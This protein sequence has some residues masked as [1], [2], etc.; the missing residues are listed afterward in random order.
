MYSYRMKEMIIEHGVMGS[1]GTCYTWNRK[2]VV[3]M[4]LMQQVTKR[5]MI[6]WKSDSMIGLCFAAWRGKK[7]ETTS[8]NTG[9][10]VL[11]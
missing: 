11:H 6:E 3:R 10:L 5:R 1:K 9:E 2:F 7:Q 8:A 4:Q